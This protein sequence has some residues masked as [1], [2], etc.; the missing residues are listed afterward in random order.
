MTTVSDKVDKELERLKLAEAREHG[1]LTLGDLID[2]IGMILSEN[3]GKDFPIVGRAKFADS[4]DFYL[5]Y[6]I[7][8]VDSYRGYYKD[9]FIEC[10][11]WGTNYTRGEI[12]SARS[13]HA[14]LV[15]NVGQEVSGYK[16]GYYTMD[17]DT[18]MWFANWQRDCT[19]VMIVDVIAYGLPGRKNHN[20]VPSRIEIQGKWIPSDLTLYS[21]PNVESVRMKNL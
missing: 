21:V 18:L 20:R 5:G 7:P 16:G 1:Q 12:P 14:Q 17:R 11:M 15:K 8:Y 4:V 6:P 2:R 3:P 10:S 19:C 9:G 13:F